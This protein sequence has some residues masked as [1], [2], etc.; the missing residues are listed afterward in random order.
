M[1][2]PRSRPVERSGVVYVAPDKLGGVASVLANLVTHRG[3]AA[4]P[5]SVVFTHNRHDPDARYEGALR[6]HLRGVVEHAL[7]YENRYAVLR[8]LARAIPAGGGVLVCNDGLELEAAALRDPG[9]M[10]VQIL[11]GDYEYYYALAE[12]HAAA[13]DVFVACSERIARVL[14]ERLPARAESVVHLRHGV[15]LPARVRTPAAGALRLLFVGR[16][17][18]A[19]GVLDLPAIDRALRERGVAA[20]WTVVG[21]GPAEAALRERWRAAPDV[22]WRGRLDN[23]AVLAL[24]AEH[25]AFVLP[26]RAEGFPVA[27]LEAM[28]TGVVPVVSDLPSG[29]PELVLHGSTGYVAPVGDV[30][31]FADAIAALDRDRDRLE[32]MSEAARRLVAERHDVRAQ[33]AAYEALFAR[34]RELR[35]PRAARLPLPAANRLD[36]PWLPNALVYAVRSGVHLLN[37]RAG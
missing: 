8:R 23:A 9:R 36:R 15:A 2:S 4:M 27:L 29:I 20:R 19:K 30:P 7:P 25:D 10:V 1:T 18:A 32:A 24:C 34:W 37:R 26:S 33:T 17:D 13:I 12:R 3:P 5:A 28:G 31:A 35:R 21:A 6:S 14:R 11:H 16:L 22:E